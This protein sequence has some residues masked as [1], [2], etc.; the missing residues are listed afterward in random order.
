MLR[1]HVETDLGNWDWV[2]EGQAGGG[3]RMIELLLLLL[4]FCWLLAIFGGWEGPGLR[5][6]KHVIGWLTLF[7]S[8]FL[9]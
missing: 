5:T 8:F 3:M 4:P 9:I 7:L 1:E 2:M 6:G